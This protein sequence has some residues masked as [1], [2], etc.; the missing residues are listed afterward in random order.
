MAAPAPLPAVPDYQLDKAAPQMGRAI[1]VSGSKGNVY[2]APPGFQNPDLTCG[3]GE[4]P[5]SLGQF[6][7]AQKTS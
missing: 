2:R 3:P 5:Q 7:P 6:Y 4:P 1:V